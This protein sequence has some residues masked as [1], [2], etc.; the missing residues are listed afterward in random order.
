M[1][2]SFREFLGNLTRGLYILNDDFH[3]ESNIRYKDVHNLVV[4]LDDVKAKMTA[5]QTQ[6]NQLMGV[7][8][9]PAPAPTVKP[10]AQAPAVTGTHAP[11]TN[12]GACVGTGGLKSN[13]WM[14]LIM[15]K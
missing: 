8:G 6:V 10:G 7:T 14:V 1:V 2:C 4:S 13:T 3:K 11:S 12:T 9:N 5:L 15:Q